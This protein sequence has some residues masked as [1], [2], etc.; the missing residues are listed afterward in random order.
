MLGGKKW[1]CKS[2][3][4]S[5]DLV[6]KELIEDDKSVFMVNSYQRHYVWGEMQI[7]DFLNDIKRITAKRKQDGTII[8]YFGQFIYRKI[9]TDRRNRTTYEIVDGQQRMT[10]FLL[11]VAALYGNA[12]AQASSCV[13]TEKAQKFVASCQKYLISTGEGMPECHKLCLSTQENEYF[14]SLLTALENR[15]CPDCPT[16]KSATSHTSLYEAYSIIKTHIDK[17]IAAIPSPD[18]VIETISEQLSAVV[19]GFQIL[20]I[21]PTKEEYTYQLYQV[22]NDRG[23]PLT[24]SELLKAKTAEFLLRNEHSAEALKQWDIILQDPGKE[25]KK[26]LDWCY[27]SMTG[28]AAPS[29]HFHTKFLE[30]YFGITE[31][32]PNNRENQEAFWE[33]LKILFEDIQLCK[34]L[35]SGVWPYE[36]DPNNAVA[37]WQ[38]DILT[39]LIVKGKH[40]LCIPVLLSAYHNPTF[41][42][43]KNKTTGEQNFAKVLEL[44]EN[45]YLLVIVVCS[46]SEM[47]F[48]EIYLTASKEMRD[49]KKIFRWKDFQALLCNIKKTDVEASCRN[50]LNAIT[51]KPKGQ[52][53]GLKYLLIIL[54]RYFTCFNGR[55]FS[56]SQ[57]PD[58]F[59][60]ISSELSIEHI[61]AESADKLDEELEQQKHFV[62]NLL[63]YGRKANSDLKNLPYNRKRLKYSEQPFR[64]V[65]YI[66]STYTEWNIDGFNEYKEKTVKMLETILLRFYT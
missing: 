2:M 33:K 12:K 51:Y 38:K 29:D 65:N 5:H 49:N 53:P 46:W 58:G 66:A 62:G 47:K 35:Q 27:M 21:I 9:S 34:K 41:G 64:T 36:E 13:D 57:V 22:L 40:T 16:K 15:T 56:P 45:T 1:G 14:L 60:M 19:N 8:H 30:D 44:C 48:K 59:S 18:E 26:Y 24:D 28:K 7:T 37:R 42:S 20:S 54:E 6:L 3:I 4:E 11:Y 31:D 17:E 61:Y 43:G 25:T 55:T 63:I 52:N 23:E 32:T 10:T 39:N 50:N